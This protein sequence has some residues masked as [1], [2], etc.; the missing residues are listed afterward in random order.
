MDTEELPG[1]CKIDVLYDFPGYN[2][3]DDNFYEIYTTLLDNNRKITT[4][5]VYLEDA[6][7]PPPNYNDLKTYTEIILEEYKN[8]N[9]SLLVCS[10]INTQKVADKVL[11]DIGFQYTGWNPIG[12]FKKI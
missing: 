1:N 11:R 7:Y 6:D 3:D 9:S 12:P 10:L 8:S 4:K 5:G 2:D